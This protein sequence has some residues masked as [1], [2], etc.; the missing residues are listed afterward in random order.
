[1]FRFEN[2]SFL[3]LF[4]LL[5]IIVLIYIVLQIVDRRKWAR[6]GDEK[7]LGKLMPERSRAMKHLK[8]A[9][10]M[11]AF[12]CFI[13]AAANPQTAGKV[14]KSKRKGVDV[15][16][17]LDVSNSMLARD[18]QPNRLAACKMA[19]SR[20]IDQ[21]KGDRVGVVIFAGTA[22]VQLPATTDYAA[23]KMFINQIST[24][25][26]QNQGTD[27]SAA[28]RTAD[29]ALNPP[30]DDDA[31]PATEPSQV[32][33]Q[34]IVLVSDGEDHFP[35]SAQTAK[36]LHE[37]GT[38]IHTI[39]IGSVEGTTI[40]MKNGEGV[41]KD[42]DGNTVITHLNERALQD[43]AENAGGVYVHAKNTSASFNAILTEIDNM[44]K[45]DIDDVNFSNFNSWFQYPLA[46]GLFLL[47]IEGL[48]FAVRPKWQDVLV[49]MRRKLTRKS[50]VM[51]L[52]LLVVLCA[53]CQ[54]DK[55]RPSVIQEANRE[56]RAGDSLCE[57]A[58]LFE[59]DSEDDTTGFHSYSHA[60]SLYDS[61][62]VSEPVNQSQAAFN[63]I[64]AYYRLRNFDT[65]AHLADSLLSVN[66]DKQL[67]AKVFYNKGNALMKQKHYGDAV[68]AFKESL[69]RNPNDQ[70]AKYNLVYAKKMLDQHGNGGGG[71]QQ[72]QQ[73]Q[74]QQNQNQQQQQNQQDQQQQGQQQQQQG[75]GEN[76]DSNEKKQQQSATLRQLDALQQNEKGVQMRMQKSGEK[77]QNE[78]SDKQRQEKD[79]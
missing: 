6:F 34:V 18:I 13:L 46:V 11:L 33:S 20:F 64:D 49:N 52:I 21:L 1:M 24:D 36:E 74:Q 60:L 68:D 28:L 51:A 59:N 12:A 27:L 29:F 56:F 25:Q 2:E 71:G 45:S 76:D 30:Q 62:A 72:N 50:A 22:F 16:F 65:I 57:S 47:L 48:L 31:A 39:G 26:I 7:L 77:Y 69:R 14:E 41:K 42:R 38:V 8:F 55:T 43:V 37:K 3:Y 10:V 63:Q 78:K 15:M 40:P 32:A 53:A 54:R 75:G 9:L 66:A 19:M 4:A 23:A 5:G 35:E 44:E 17:C 58:G 61:A 79:W 70:D 73:N 67:A